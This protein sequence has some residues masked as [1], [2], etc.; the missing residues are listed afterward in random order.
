MVSRSSSEFL[1]QRSPEA[2][3]GLYAPSLVMAP[4]NAGLD[5]GFCFRVFMFFFFFVVC[6]Q[7][8]SVMLKCYWT[9]CWLRC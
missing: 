9:I 3:R 7:F 4:F 5:V 6:S 1:L 2:A 8:A